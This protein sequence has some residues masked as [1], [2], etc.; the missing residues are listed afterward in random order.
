MEDT[1]QPP[2]VA[3]RTD[4]TQIRYSQY[5]ADRVQNVAL[6]RAVQARDGVELRVEPR[7]HRPRRI[8]L[9]PIDYDLADKH[10]GADPLTTNKEIDLL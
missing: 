8:G 10:F 4:L 5:K 6:A 9:K 7:D 3:G 2:C 1:G